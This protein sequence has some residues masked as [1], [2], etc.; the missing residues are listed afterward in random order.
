MF[1]ATTDLLAWVLLSATALYVG[2]A[3]AFYTGLGRFTRAAET[4]CPFVSVVVAARDEEAYIQACVESL[5]CQTYPAD[6]FEILVVDDGSRDRTS[7]IA[8]RLADRHPQ[9]RALSVG[10]AFPELA[11]KKRPLSVGIGQARGELILTTDADCRVPPTWLAGMVACFQP[12]VGVVI[13]YSEVKPRG[14]TLTFFERLQALDFLALMSA[15]AGSANVGIPLAASGQNLAYRKAL[16]D[17]VGGFG[18]IGSRPSGDDVLLLQLMRRAGQGRI[19]FSGSEETRVSTWRSESLRGFWRQ[20]CR[21]ASNASCQFRLNP[22]FSVY[23]AAVFLVSL[24]A[25]TTLII[26]TGG[27]RGLPLACWGA[28]AI[29]DLAVLWR[30]ARAFGRPDLLLVLPVWEIL[31]APYTVLVGVLGNLSGF[32]W[33]GRR[34]T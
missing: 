1:P 23:L 7:E 19:V 3:I 31:H 20:R 17:A 13:G 5:A 29:A 18:P 34:H 28:K 11:A 8:S 21:W 6:R 24:L 2:V 10:N 33:K 26:G 4:S 9:V 16:F 32:T 22:A 25:P 12:D 27:G 30:G 14:H 15:S